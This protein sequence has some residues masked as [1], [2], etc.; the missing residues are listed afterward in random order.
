MRGLILALVAALVA[1]DFSTSKTYV[2]KYEALLLGGLPN[3]GLAR[4]GVK[5][6]S[7]VLISGIA[8]NTYLL[9][10]LHVFSLHFLIF[11]ID[12]FTPAQKL[13]EALSA[14]LRTPIKFEYTNGVRCSPSLWDCRSQRLQFPFAL[15][16]L[17]LML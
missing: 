12:Q 10:L 13:T 11:Q 2:Y 3:E 17:P 1:P 5:I 4:A 6:V 9:Q 8:Q 15:V 16:S 7:K 14:Q